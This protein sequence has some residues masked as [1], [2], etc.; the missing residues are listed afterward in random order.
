MDTA[1]QSASGTQTIN[2][3][4]DSR[5]DSAISAVS[6]GA[7]F[8]GGVTAAAMALILLALGSGLGLSSVSPWQNAG[9]SAKAIGIA[10]AIWL[11]VMQLIASGLGGYLAGR[12]RT[13]WVGI[14]TDETFFRDTAH[15]FLVWA[16]GIVVT[17]ALL[18]TAA[19]A[20]VG[21]AASGATVLTAGAGA[22]MAAPAA[23]AIDTGP[24]ATGAL[25]ASQ[26]GQN[27]YLADQLLRTD[28][29]AAGAADETQLRGEIGRI[30][31]NSMKNGALA[32]A[33]R[34]YL[35]QTI[36]ARTGMSQADAEKRVDDVT[37]QAKKAADDA[38]AAADT[39]RKAAAY[40]SL[41]IFISLLIGAFSASFAATLGGRARDRIAVP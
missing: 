6:W 34:T 21:T 19:S 20:M 35:A 1:L 11:A 9:A 41:W 30:F 12:L 39:A 18:T 24:S 16:F 3:I 8:A 14:H 27:A 40:T 17:A 36:A 26:G 33:D 23:N 37:A 22:A 4:P 38:R 28:G 25:S 15:G 29:T 32:P 13:R 2:H 31:A 7:V 10:A 5:N